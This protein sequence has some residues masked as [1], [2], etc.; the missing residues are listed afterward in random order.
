[1]VQQRQE[2]RAVAI[3]HVRYLREQR[4]ALR[5]FA[6]VWPVREFVVEHPVTEWSDVIEI[7]ARAWL[8]AVAPGRR[9][10]IC[11]KPAGTPC[12][13]RRHV[14]RRATGGVL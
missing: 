1:M 14:A 11:G 9:C 3:E 4:R 8:H 12:N 5:P 2:A 13:Q 10:S 7:Y 6:A